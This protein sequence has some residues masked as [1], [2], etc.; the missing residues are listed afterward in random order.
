MNY[1]L[2]LNL[3]VDS[4]KGGFV[5]KAKKTYYVTTTPIHLFLTLKYKG[6]ASFPNMNWCSMQGT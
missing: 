1:S 5:K 2:T 4:E 6:K 3:A